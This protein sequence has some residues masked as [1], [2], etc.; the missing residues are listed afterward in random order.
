MAKYL[1][2]L[3]ERQA[4]LIMCALDLYTRVGTGQLKEVV[5]IFRQFGKMKDGEEAWKSHDRWA[6][7]VQNV[8]ED[9]CVVVTG[10]PAQGAHSIGSHLVHDRFRQAYDIL[11]VMRHRIAWDTKPAPVVETLDHD[12]PDVSSYEFKEL[13]VMTGHD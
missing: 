11:K 1:L 10:F 12:K 13:P 6:T 2:E 3:D 4:R 9:L 8:T 5:S 7:S